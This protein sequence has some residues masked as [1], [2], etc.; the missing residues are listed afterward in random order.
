VETRLLP[1]VLFLSL[2]V[3]KDSIAVSRAPSD[4]TEVRRYGSIGTR[5]RLCPRRGEGNTGGKGCW[6][7]RQTGRGTERG[8]ELDGGGGHGREGDGG[9]TCWRTT[10]NGR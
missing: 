8:P 3:H 7:K 9:L 2:D 4:S 1:P 10:S 5:R 6:G